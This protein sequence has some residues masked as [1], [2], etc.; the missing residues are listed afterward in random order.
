MF[1]CQIFPYIVKKKQNKETQEEFKMADEKWRRALKTTNY[2]DVL[3][4]LK[5][6]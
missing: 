6:F 1:M 5:F 3:F 4:L 2:K